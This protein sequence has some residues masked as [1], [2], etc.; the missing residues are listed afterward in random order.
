MH[1]ISLFVINKLTTTG[2][3]KKMKVPTGLYFQ[4]K[5]ILLCWTN[6]TGSETLLDGLPEYFYHRVTQTVL[7]KITCHTKYGTQLKHFAVPSQVN[8]KQTILF[9]KI[10]CS[11]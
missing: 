1:F 2:Q 10:P 4:S 3:T 9:I 11:A 6:N 7:V 5:E 8:N